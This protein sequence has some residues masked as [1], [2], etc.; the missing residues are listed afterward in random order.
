MAEHNV[1]E[2][3]PKLNLPIREALDILNA[4]SEHKFG[5][6]LQM[7]KLLSLVNTIVSRISISSLITNF[8]Q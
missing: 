8:N 2:I 7:V 5:P 4:S 1:K 6:E 3:A